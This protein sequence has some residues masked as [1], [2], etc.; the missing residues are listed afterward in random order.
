MGRQTKGIELKWLLLGMFFG[1]IGNS[2]V[3]PLTTIYMHQQLHESL[4]VSGIVLL[5]YSGANVVGSYISGLL[6]DKRNPRHLMLAGVSLAT[7]VIATMIFF[8]DWPIYAILLTAIGFFN[9][10]IITMV[11]SF[12]TKLRMDGRYVFNMLYFANNLG[13]VIGTTIVGPLYQYAHGNISPLFSITTVLYILFTLVVFFYF[14]EDP[15][16]QPV[17]ETRFKSDE[18]AVTKIPRANLWISWIFFI[19][20][21]IVW[22]MYEQWSSNLS[23]FMTS[24]GISMT[25]YSLLW[26]L[27][28]VLI[29]LIQLFLTWLN[30]FY[31]NP[32]AQVYVGIF[33]VGLSFV[34][35][36]FATNYLW[37]VIA[38]IILTIGEATAFP[39]MPAIVN[40]LSPVEVK[41]KY[42]GIL[43]AFSSL[44]KAFGPLFGGLVIGAAS[45]HVLFVICAVSIF[46]MEIIVV[47]VVRLQ[48]PHT[49]DY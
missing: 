30:R 2:F 39:T 17:D 8:N 45:Y 6:F 37:F 13:M 3:W 33:T 5:F 40:S 1:S 44:G 24:Q 21:C 31:N 29:V 7:V 35:L 27:N 18:P 12:G 20:L 19:T 32:Y 43:N 14:H 34:L 47:L 26:T 23:V 15:H 49:V 48:K 25:K 11:N 36:L 41:G 28:G 4:T 46:V 16:P 10:W 9:G 42:Q 22:T 38:M